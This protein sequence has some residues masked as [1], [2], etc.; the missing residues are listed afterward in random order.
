MSSEPQFLSFKGLKQY[1]P[2]E[3]WGQVNAILQSHTQPAAVPENVPTLT[4]TPDA[5]ENTSPI[6]DPLIH[7]LFEQLRVAPSDELT[8]TWRTIAAEVNLLT[9][10]MA[11]QRELQER[12]HKLDQDLLDLRGTILSHLSDVQHAADQQLSSARL[13]AEV[14]ALAQSKLAAKLTNP[15]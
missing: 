10:R 2:E 15:R 12:L 13:R 9:Q 6:F 4:E 8:Q 1:S 7:E 14:S 5:R 11:L 3:G